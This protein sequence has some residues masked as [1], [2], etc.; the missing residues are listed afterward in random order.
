MRKQEMLNLL[1]AAGVLVEV[2]LI[3]VT[4]FAED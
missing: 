1:Y 2:M 3:A 4:Y